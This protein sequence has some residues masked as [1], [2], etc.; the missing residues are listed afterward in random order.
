M[1]WHKVN[2][3]QQ[4][5]NLINHVRQSDSPVVPQQP[6]LCNDWYDVN[7]CKRAA[8]AERVPTKRNNAP[9]NKMP[10]AEEIL[11]EEV[12]DLCMDCG[13]EK[14]VCICEMWKKANEEKL[15]KRK[16]DESKLK[17]KGPTPTPIREDQ[18]STSQPTRPR[19]VTLN[20][21]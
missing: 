14:K 21:S 11:P 4:Y 20:V 10:S 12:I 9:T 19:E 2:A 7:V 5:F 16:A 6:K 15:Q 8:L 3:R 1:P 17:E 13:F 18:P